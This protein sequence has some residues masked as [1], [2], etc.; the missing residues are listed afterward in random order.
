MQINWGII[1]CGD[2][3]ELKSGPAFRKVPHSELV[4]VMRRNA[5]K[6]EDYAL[7]HGVKKW[8]TDAHDLIRDPELNAVYIAT[9]PD[10]HAFYTMEALKA[11][12]A[13]YVEKPMARNAS[14]A[15]KMRD[16]ALATG[17]PLCVAHY[18]RAQPKFIKIKEII[19]SGQLGEIRNV[20]LEHLQNTPPYIEQGWRLKADVSGGG[21]FHDLAPHQLD[22]MLF[23]FGD[24]QDIRLG[25]EAPETRNTADLL[26]AEISFK[27]IPFRGLWHFRSETERDICI[28]TGSRASLRFPIFGEGAEL[29]PNNGGTEGDILRFEKL[30]H[31][32]QP[33]IEQ[34][35]K[36]FRNEGP[37]PCS[38]QEGLKV[39]E[40]I[41]VISSL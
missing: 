10:S 16:S 3:T 12:K 28:V 29:K 8:Y 38:A 23:L 19:D 20:Q 22:L 36:Y 26:Q 14:E 6:A 32:Q 15:A 37:N 17:S 18:R 25:S 7:R 1:G 40:M 4:A 11:G 34:V 35:V 41:D 24:P 27:G 21:L 13:V 2:V 9:P 31:V 30:Q 33:M 5:A 39:M